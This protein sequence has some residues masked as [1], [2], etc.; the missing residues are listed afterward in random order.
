VDPLQLRAALPEPR[1]RPS[2]PCSAFE[3]SA[4]SSIASA[5]RRGVRRAS[6]AWQNPLRRKGDRLH[7]RICSPC[8]LLL[9]GHARRLLRRYAEYYND[10]DAF[11]RSR[12]SPDGR[13]VTAR[14][15][16]GS[17]SGPI[18]HTGRRY[19]GKRDSCGARRRLARLSERRPG[20]ALRTASRPATRSVA[21]V[22]PLP[23]RAVVPRTSLCLCG[24]TFR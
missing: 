7:R 18:G 1:A 16:R 15:T 6:V 9:R 19:H 4:T 17:V 14:N 21:S 23:A 22:P 24:W 8:D 10:G 11:S 20:Y 2:R 3:D 12:G 13:A 5:A